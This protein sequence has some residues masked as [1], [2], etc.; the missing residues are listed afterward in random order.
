LFANERLPAAPAAGAGLLPPLE[1]GA[2][3][4]TPGASTD[5]LGCTCDSDCQTGAICIDESAFGQPQGFCY[6]ECTADNPCGPGASCDPT[7]AAPI[8]ETNCAGP[9]DCP[10]GR[11]CSGGTC[12]PTCAADSDC[13]SGHCDRDTALC[14]DGTPRTGD[15]L[16]SPC[17]HSEDCASGNCEPTSNRCITNCQLSR[18]VHCPTGAVCVETRSGD[19]LGLCLYPCDPLFRICPRADLQCNYAGPLSTPACTPTP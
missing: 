5:G 6:R 7:A 12:Y 17:L 19:D 13:R 14:S 3:C 18:P 2:A 9:A 8:C 16:W 10:P 11:V 4:G 15:P 1:S